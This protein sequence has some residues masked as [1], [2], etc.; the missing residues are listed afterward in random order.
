MTGVGSMNTHEKVEATLRRMKIEELLEEVNWYLIPED[1]VAGDHSRVPIMK[2]K[3][4]GD[5]RS[6][7]KI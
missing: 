5:W 1:K 7:C 2:I 6:K 3:W 4:R